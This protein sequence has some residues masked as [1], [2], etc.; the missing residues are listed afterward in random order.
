[1][2]TINRR[3]FLRGSAS[4]ATAAGFVAAPAVAAPAD[5]AAPSAGPAASA[6]TPSLVIAF[7][8]NDS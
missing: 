2:S 6:L 5:K 1:M 3:A 4:L 8:A 7:S